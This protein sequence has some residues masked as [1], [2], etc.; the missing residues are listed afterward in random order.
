[1][2]AAIA[3]KT[4][5]AIATWEP[6]PSLLEAKGLVKVLQRGGKY[7]KSPGC[8]M[9]GTAYIDRNRDAVQRFVKAHVR[10]CEFIRR[11]PRE[12]SVI[13]AKY[14]KGSTADVIEQSYR[15]LVFDPRVTPAMLREFEADMRFMLGQK[16]IAK[17]VEARLI[18]TSVFTD[19]V[20]KRYPDLLKDLR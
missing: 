13:N 15:Y 4:V 6:Q 12:A 19:E 18:A 3:A 5:D 1:M 8:V 2:A 7:L 11:Q 16:K 14:V 20:E 10:A 17:A 9:F